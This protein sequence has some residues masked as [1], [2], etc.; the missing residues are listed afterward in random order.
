[1]DVPIQAGSFGE[2]GVGAWEEEGG[3]AWGELSE[4]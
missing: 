1:M 2:R 4:D 3:E